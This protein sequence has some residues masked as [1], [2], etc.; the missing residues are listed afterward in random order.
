M[1]VAAGRWSPCSGLLY[2]K[3]QIS[4]RVLYSIERRIWANPDRPHGRYT[5]M[6]HMPFYFLPAVISKISELSLAI[7]MASLI[8]ISTEMSLIFFIL[9]IT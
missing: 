5:S 3:L 4:E 9:S 7:L 6:T 1:F 8:L 2:E